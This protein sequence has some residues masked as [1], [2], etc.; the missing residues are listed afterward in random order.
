MASGP[1]GPR[2]AGRI[3][4]GTALVLYIVTGLT[5][6]LAVTGI[7]TLSRPALWGATAAS[8]VVVAFAI[9]QLVATVN[10]V[11][12]L[13]KRGVLAT[14]TITNVTERYV[15]V[16][17]GYTGW[18]TAVSVSFTDERGDLI[19][20]GYSD[21][22]AR[23]AGRQVGQTVQIRYDPREPTSV[24]PAAEVER[25]NDTRSFEAFL[26]GTGAAAFLAMSLYFAYQATR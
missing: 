14:A 22:Y 6:L 12:R 24:N 3:G 19:T 16:P 5:W 21:H 11:A 8:L 10:T 17:Y 13:R 26:I 2:V 1:G 9:A 4:R 20:A 25:G 15:Q 7:V 23:A 18:I